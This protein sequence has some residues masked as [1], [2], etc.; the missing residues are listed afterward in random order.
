MFADAQGWVG[1]NRILFRAVCCRIETAKTRFECSAAETIEIYFGLQRR[2]WRQKCEKVSVT[3]WPVYLRSY[4]NSIKVYQSW[5][6]SFT[7]ILHLFR[8]LAGV[9]SNLS[10]IFNTAQ[11]VL[12]DGTPLG[13][14]QAGI[15]EFFKTETD[16]DA[17]AFVWK[18]WR[19]VTG[20]K[21]KTLFVEF[22]QLMNEGAKKYGK[23]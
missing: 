7:D 16:Y 14:S 23:G 1:S 19:D 4:L 12:Q 15:V 6:N 18:K 9:T 3:I 20:R 2:Q 21:M 22:V 13:V 8:H 11:V 17:L 5:C 10:A